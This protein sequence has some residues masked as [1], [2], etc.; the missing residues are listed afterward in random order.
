MFTKI[1]SYIL[2][3]SFCVVALLAGSA[4]ANA[5]S[6]NRVVDIVD[7]ASAPIYHLYISN[8]GSGFWGPDQL[9]AYQSIS[10]NHYR[11]FNIDDGTGYCVFDLMAV[12]SDG[13]VAITRNFNVCSQS[14][15]TV[16]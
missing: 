9:G 8:V 6:Y 4:R 14:S 2:V 10:I 15:W 7:Q 5:Q 11:T 3:A 13:R 16:Y 12:L 1:R